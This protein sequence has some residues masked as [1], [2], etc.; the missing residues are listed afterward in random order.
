MARGRPHLQGFL[1]I[2]DEVRR[3]YQAIRVK[4]L[5]DAPGASEE[6]LEEIVAMGRRY[7]P[8]FDIVTNPVP[9]TVALA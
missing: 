1:G 8:V 9:V 2:S 5:V 3:G 4:F 7:S 6:D